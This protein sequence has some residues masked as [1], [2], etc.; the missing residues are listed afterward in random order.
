MKKKR[1]K[2]GLFI[3]NYYPNI[4]GVTMV[5]DNLARCLTK[6]ADV[7]VVCP[8]ID[9]C[10]DKG[11][12]YKVI[13][14]KSLKVPFTSYK[15]V[16]VFCSRLVMFFRLLCVSRSCLMSVYALLGGVS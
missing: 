14:L 16:D 10:D 11:F 8:Y 1:M 13:R 15:I 6:Y 5:V 4:D 2:V 3:D 9:G 7:V 12:P